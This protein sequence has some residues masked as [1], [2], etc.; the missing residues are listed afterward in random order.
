MHPRINL[1]MKTKDGQTVLDVAQGEGANTSFLDYLCWKYETQFY[2]CM[3]FFGV[4][5]KNAGE[6]LSLFTA[7]L[8]V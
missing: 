1:K 2:W 4:T 6:E 5:E 7:N 8:N 3:K